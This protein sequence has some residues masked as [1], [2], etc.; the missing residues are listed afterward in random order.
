VAVLGLLQARYTAGVWMAFGPRHLL[1]VSCWW[2]CSQCIDISSVFLYMTDMVGL[3][4]RYG[5]ESCETGILCTLVLCASDMDDFAGLQRWPLT[6][7]F[8]ILT[9]ITSSYGKSQSDKCGNSV[10][11][12]K[13]R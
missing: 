12:M 1:L 6:G 5:S 2:M 10:L 4:C 7:Y 8:V 13:M 11:K 9:S 3:G